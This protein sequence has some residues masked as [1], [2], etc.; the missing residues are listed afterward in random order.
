MPIE[1]L[2]YGDSMQSL[3]WAA[4]AIV[5]PRKSY[6]S[7]EVRMPLTCIIVSDVTIL[8]TYKKRYRRQYKC[9][10]F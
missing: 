2:Q 5:D 1:Q 3:K 9:K 10:Q 4:A 8:G 7:Q 6:P